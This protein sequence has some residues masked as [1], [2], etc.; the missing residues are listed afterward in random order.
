MSKNCG[1]NA[2]RKIN[3]LGLLAETR[4]ASKNKLLM[5]LSMRES[6]MAPEKP[7]LLEDL[8]LLIPR[9]TR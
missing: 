4:N 5:D 2:D 1:K 8:R 3:V 6:S 7:D 9:Y